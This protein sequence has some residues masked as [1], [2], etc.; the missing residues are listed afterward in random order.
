MALLAR[1]RV[2]VAATLAE[3]EGRVLIIIIRTHVP[4]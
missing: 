4:V 2:N 1:S 3:M